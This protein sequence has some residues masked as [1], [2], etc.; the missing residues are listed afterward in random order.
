M[1]EPSAIAV[2]RTNDAVF[3]SGRIVDN[4][5]HAHHAMQLTWAVG[6]RALLTTGEPFSGGVL[7]VE[8]G[9]RHALRLER[10]LLCLL[11]PEGRAARAIRE[12]W[13]ASAE[14]AVVAETPLTMLDEPEAMLPP[15]TGELTPRSTDERIARVLV[16]LDELEA[17]ER[18]PEVSIADAL[19]LVHLSESRF[20]HLFTDEV[21][22][23]WRSY[24]V[25]RRALVAASLALRGATLTEAAHGAGYADS[26]HLSRQFKALFGF[27]PSRALGFSRLVQG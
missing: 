22:S 15:L 24:L 9:V 21:G 13:L 16:W 6:E 5:P 26:A 27:T 7:A 1:S 11:E 23:S 17:S 3:L 8:G 18:W 19:P 4:A 14:V 10:G 2:R 12:R 20:R 25:W